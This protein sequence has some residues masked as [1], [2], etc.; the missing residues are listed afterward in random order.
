VVANSSWSGQRGFSYQ[1]YFPSVG[2]TGAEVWG[3]PAVFNV[4]SIEHDFA[5]AKAAYPRLNSLRLWMSVD[6]FISNPG[7][8]ADQLDSVLALGERFGIRFIVTLFNWWQGVPDWGGRSL[9]ESSS[10]PSMAPG[11]GYVTRDHKSPVLAFLE[12]VVLPNARNP[13]VQLWDIGN[14][15]RGPSGMCQPQPGDDLRPLQHVLN[16]T[17]GWL[18]GVAK[19]AAPIGVSAGCG[20]HPGTDYCLRQYNPFKPDVLL[21]HA[22]CQH[23]YPAANGSDAPAMPQYRQNLDQAVA[24]ANELGIP[25]MATEGCWGEMDD[26]KRAKSCA[27]EMH[28]LVLRGIG[29]SPHALRYSKVAD[30]HDFDGGPVGGAGYMAFL[31]KNGTVRPYHE[32]PV[33]FGY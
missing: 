20:T 9:V 29:L 13:A 25:L 30:L 28:E 31:G 8:Y 32:F 33:K 27:A 22:Y 5:A 16:W 10:D 1:P 14:E 23:C 19:V 17:A 21:L 26:E 12:A 2:G 4:S 11:G 24:Y 7:S 15:P 6:G 18:R 3:Q